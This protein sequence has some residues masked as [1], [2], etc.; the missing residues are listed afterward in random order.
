MS[1]MPSQMMGRGLGEG[2][3]SG[4]RP[5]EAEDVDF[6]DSRV[7]DQMKKGETVYGGKVGGDNRKGTTQSEVQDAVLT[8]LSEEPEPLDDTP[9][10]K[11]QREHS[12]DYFNSLR[13]G[14]AGE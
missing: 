13:E 11:L 8:S 3:G 10:P 14:S 2:Q 12:R 9:L 5:E 1:S 4:E 7:R 6:F